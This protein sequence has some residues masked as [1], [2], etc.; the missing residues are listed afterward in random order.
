M[1]HPIEVIEG[2]FSDRVNVTTAGATF[3][4]GNDVLL[5]S[6]ITNLNILSNTDNVV[7][8]E[9]TAEEW[10]MTAKMSVKGYQLVVMNKLV[11][12]KAAAGLPMSSFRESYVSHKQTTAKK[13]QTCNQS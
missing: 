6:Q 12:E 8:V 9:I 11:S 2:D 1:K 5:L 13:C 4:S 3:K 10:S 7:I